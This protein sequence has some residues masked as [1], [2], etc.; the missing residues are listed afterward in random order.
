MDIW[1]NPVAHSPRSSL[2]ECT[3]IPSMPI[4]NEPWLNQENP[5]LFHTAWAQAV[6][7]SRQRATEGHKNQNRVW[8]ADL[9][10]GE[11]M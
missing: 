8:A 5:R 7:G 6:P 3:A 4:Q 9:T 11:G 1:E 2:L 10:S